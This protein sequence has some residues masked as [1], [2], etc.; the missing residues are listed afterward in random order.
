M[1]VEKAKDI[2]YNSSSSAAM[3][4]DNTTFIS[5]GRVNPLGLIAERPHMSAKFGPD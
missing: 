2:K 3:E 4:I 1:R 5:M